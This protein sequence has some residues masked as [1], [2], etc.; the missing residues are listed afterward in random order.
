MHNRRV[1]S[2]DMTQGE[3]YRLVDS[4]LTVEGLRVRECCWCRPGVNIMT[5]DKGIVSPTTDKYD[6]DA[7]DSL[8]GQIQGSRQVYLIRHWGEYKASLASQ[9]LVLLGEEP[10]QGLQS[11]QV[12]TTSIS[13]VSC[14]KW[15]NHAKRSVALTRFNIT[16]R[17]HW[18]W[19]LAPP[20][21]MQD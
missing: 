2:N 10:Q 13:T 3:P 7:Q 17:S 20:L 19:L 8:G 21:V 14:L 4:V 1:L 5:I 6:R 12:N 15:T 9:N 18:L 11:G 16:L